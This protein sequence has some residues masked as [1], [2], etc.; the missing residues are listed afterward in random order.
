MRIMQEIKRTNE[1]FVNTYNNFA[2]LAL[3]LR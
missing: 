3:S 1:Q 2:L